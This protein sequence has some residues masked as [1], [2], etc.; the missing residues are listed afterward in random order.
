MRGGSP[1]RLS[2]A[3]RKNN[4]LTALGAAFGRF[5]GIH[6]ALLSMPVRP[7]GY[8]HGPTGRPSGRS[9]RRASQCSAL[10][11]FHFE[12][13]LTA[14]VIVL[15][16]DNIVFTQIGTALNLNDLQRLRPGIG[17]TVPGP[18]GDVRGLVRM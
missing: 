17:Q 8:R 4:N 6:T 5:A 11:Q 18:D 14:A 2:P 9:S 10:E 12:I 3:G 16:A 1:G 15:K 7:L 13:A